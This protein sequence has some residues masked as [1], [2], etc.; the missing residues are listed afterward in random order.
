M[1]VIEDGRDQP[2]GSSIHLHIKRSPVY[3]VSEIGEQSAT[4]D[5][6]H[7]S[8]HPQRSRVEVE[9]IGTARWFSPP[10]T[11]SSTCVE[12]ARVSPQLWHAT[13]EAKFEGAREEVTSSRSAARSGCSSDQIASKQTSSDPM[14]GFDGLQAG[15]RSGRWMITYPRDVQTRMQGLQDSSARSGLEVACSRYSAVSTLRSVPRCWAA[16]LRLA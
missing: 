15:C 13:N 8:L 6:E 12:E 11:G 1:Q 7:G 10:L 3:L 16:M 14:H 2:E 9:R 5:R 4:T